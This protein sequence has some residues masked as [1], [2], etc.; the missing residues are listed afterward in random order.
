[1]KFKY[2][3]TGPTNVPL[4]VRRVD[5]PELFA[6]NPK[7][8][9]DVLMMLSSIID[10]K[11]FLE[12]VFEMKKKSKRIGRSLKAKADKRAV[13]R[14]GLELVEAA[15]RS[16]V[17]TEGT[18]DEAALREALDETLRGIS[19]VGESERELLTE[20]VV[21]AAKSRLLTEKKK[22]E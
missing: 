16:F 11:V 15:L 7:A 6:K 9:E 4:A 10:A 5:D 20:G 12:K 8:A 19:A 17:T 13:D 1:M 2:E 22:D 14:M 21:L 3:E 18:L